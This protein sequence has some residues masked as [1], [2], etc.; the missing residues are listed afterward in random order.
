MRLDRRLLPRLDPS[1]IVQDALAEAAQKLS[2]YLRERPVPLYPWLRRL[3]WE[4]LVAMHER[5]LRASRRSVAR[6][7]RSLTW[8]PD[9]SAALLADR[10]AA[11]M[12]APDR[13]LIEAEMKARLM[14]AL[15]ELAEADREILVLR[16]L[17]Q[18]PGREIAEI[19]Q[20]S[21]VAVRQRLTRA[22]ERL[23][24]RLARNLR[25]DA[26]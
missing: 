8:L 13:R 16:Y 17:E 6:E 10:I 2:D 18:L 25:E 19:L 9:E 12:A 3:A 7:E 11:N 15:A 5:H 26:P 14:E 24:K 22:V 20:I 21:E 23:A 4:H 1:D